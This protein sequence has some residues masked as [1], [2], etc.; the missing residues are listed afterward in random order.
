MILF[1]SS[2]ISGISITYTFFGVAA[3]E[4]FKYG[5]RAGQSPDPCRPIQQLPRILF[6]HARILVDLCVAAPSCLKLNFSST[7]EIVGTL[8]DLKIL[9]NISN[10]LAI[11]NFKRP[12]N[13]VLRDT[14]P[15]DNGRWFT[16]TCST[17]VGRSVP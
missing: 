11:F 3:N 14:T 8:S 5:D 13:L 10:Y 9:L 1:R 7:I 6:K 16:Y 4:G 12:Y 17:S 15:R 2:T